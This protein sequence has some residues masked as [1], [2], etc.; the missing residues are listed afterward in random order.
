MKGIKERAARRHE[1]GSSD[2]GSM[3]EQTQALVTE[4]L[5]WLANVEDVYKIKDLP[6]I[7]A[8]K[9]LGRAGSIHTSPPMASLSATDCSSPRESDTPPDSMNLILHRCELAVSAYH[10]ILKLNLPLVHSMSIV[11]TEDGFPQHR[12]LDGL[13]AIEPAIYIIRVCEMALATQKDRRTVIAPLL[14]NLF[15]K[16]LFDSATILAHIAI[17]HSQFASNL[18][19][20][21]VRSAIVL[22]RE[23][24][25]LR[26][27]TDGEKKP[28]PEP[29]RVLEILLEKGI[30]AANGGTPSATGMKRRFDEVDT[31]SADALRCNFRLPFVGAGVINMGV[32]AQRASSAPAC[33][34]EATTHD[35]SR[36]KLSTTAVSS[37]SW[38]APPDAPVAPRRN[39]S[40]NG[41]RAITVR[42]RNDG[43]KHESSRR[44][45]GGSMSSHYPPHVHAQSIAGAPPMSTRTV[46]QPQPLAIPNPS[47]SQSQPPTASQV[48]SPTELH[49][50]GF[51]ESNHIVPSSLGQQHQDQH[52][53]NPP[54]F[55]PYHP[56]P[57]HQHVQQPAF[58]SLQTP[59]E[60]PQ[61]PH[62]HTIQY[63]NS[64]GVPYQIPQH[65]Q[66]TEFQ[67]PILQKDD[68]G[69]SMPLNDSKFVLID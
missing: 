25:S 29:V 53:R 4:I 8:Y 52:S 63:F 42:I 32:A 39:S 13:Y 27:S 62:D 40:S 49:G 46:S 30:A 47:I 23:L 10:E 31:G 28:T 57:Q 64:T 9:Q 34:T 61:Q 33:G 60:Y 38:G 54:H 67:T 6:Q 35:S 66:G 59:Y 37:E 16:P 44:N 11:I 48:S 56:P 68:L 20:N 50:G 19:L 18:V 41:S 2:K 24:D 3:T 1:E 51:M 5:N 58:Q 26:G 12:H 17:H 7:G 22:F 43:S 45:R 21:G 14:S 36:V 15:T 69:N 65:F 55:G